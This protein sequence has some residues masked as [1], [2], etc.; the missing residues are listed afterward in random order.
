MKILI[1]LF[2]AFTD[3]EELAVIQR[4]IDTNKLS[5]MYSRQFQYILVH[6]GP[7]LGVWLV[8]IPWQLTMRVLSSMTGS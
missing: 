7:E 3:A 6:N 8:W 4:I 5:Q 1:Y 2:T